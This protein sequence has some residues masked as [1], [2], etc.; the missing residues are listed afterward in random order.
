ME[1]IA[2]VG[3]RC[4]LVEDDDRLAVQT[5]ADLRKMGYSVDR[6]PRLDAAL[7]MIQM[8]A[9]DAIVLDRMLPD[10]DSVTAIRSWRDAG[11]KTPVI[12]VTVMAGLHE[13]IAGLDA[14]ADDYLAKPFDV[15][16]LD[17]R[18]RALV[19]LGARQSAAPADVVQAGSIEVDYR[20]REVR[21]NGQ[22]VPIQPRE[23]KLLAELASNA[24]QVVPRAHL[25][26]RVW[27]LHFDPRTKLIETHVSRLRD[28][29]SAGG[30][31]DPIETVR[32]IGYRLRIDA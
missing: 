9:P 25:L 24:G 16:E 10:G 28:K 8:Q 2:E 21:R 6:A 22:L 31:E 15:A 14:G 3:L 18:L 23:F 12:M 26:E 4:L 1:E 30:N 29:L 27:N 17:A 32:G 13:R 11:L 7:E 20:R 5:A 19:R